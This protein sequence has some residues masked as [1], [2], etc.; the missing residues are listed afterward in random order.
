MIQLYDLME[1]SSV[2]ISEWPEHRHEKQTACQD[3]M[4]V[5]S[6]KVCKPS[7]VRTVR[8]LRPKISFDSVE[9]R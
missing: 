7:M 8:D 4:R 1:D 6:V 5:G 3:Y 2:W 9:I